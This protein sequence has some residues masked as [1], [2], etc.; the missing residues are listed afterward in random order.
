[1][2][3][4]LLKRASSTV[5]FFYI[6]LNVGF[7]LCNTLCIQ[8]LLQNLRLRRKTFSRLL[9]DLNLVHISSIK[10]PVSCVVMIWGKVVSDVNLVLDQ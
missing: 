6:S 1:M 4:L 7:S 3:D 9:R 8:F 10:L 2:L 5:K